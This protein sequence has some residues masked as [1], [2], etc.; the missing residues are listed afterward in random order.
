MIRARFMATIAAVCS[1]GAVWSIAGCASQPAPP[2]NDPPTAEH[3]SLA[4]CLSA[5]GVADTGP[6]VLGPPQGVDPQ[7]WDRAMQACSTLAP[8]PAGP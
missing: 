7:I 6:S 2:A 8:G 1:I 3:G 5:N 4:E